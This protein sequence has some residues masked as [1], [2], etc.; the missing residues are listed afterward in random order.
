LYLFLIITKGVKT[1]ASKR[2]IT[3]GRWKVKG[4]IEPQSILEL[5]L[6]KW[7]FVSS[8]IV[9]FWTILGRQCQLKL[10]SHSLEL[11]CNIFETVNIK[12]PSGQTFDRKK[13]LHVFLFCY[14]LFQTECMMFTW[15]IRSHLLIDYSNAIYVTL[16]V[17][18]L[19]IMLFSLRTWV[20][21]VCRDMI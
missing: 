12:K 14:E 16:A 3:G 18:L 11:W 8:N 2:K 10:R 19:F 4:H 5:Y 20:V 17:L 1:K 9:Y 6:R 21:D 15:D 7:I 13:N